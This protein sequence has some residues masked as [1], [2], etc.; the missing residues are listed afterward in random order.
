MP[1]SSNLEIFLPRRVPSAGLIAA[2]LMFAL[3]GDIFASETVK[4]AFV[5][6]A[7]VLQESNAMK[8]ARRRLES[9]FASRDRELQDMKKRL[10][11]LSEKFDS[12][13]ASLSD[14]DRA[15]RQR[16]LADLDKETQRKNREY[17][18]DLNLRKSE[19]LEHVKE[20][21][22]KAIRTYAVAQKYD[23]VVED[24]IYASARIDVTDRIIKSI[25]SN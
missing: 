14:A 15:R 11:S 12:E 5:N 4:V 8:D 13:S 20:V 21:T 10:K 18:E 6:T 9:E 25:N 24:A 7:R 22:A 23:L 1:R 16:E 19:L 2:S 17:L 3:S